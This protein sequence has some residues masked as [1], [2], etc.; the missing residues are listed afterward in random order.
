MS[1]KLTTNNL[2]MAESQ[3][4]QLVLGAGQVNDSI[5]QYLA[6]TLKD[7]GYKFASPS[8]LSFLS[9]LE[10]GVNYASDIARNLGVSRQ[11]VAKTVKEL[12]SAGYLDQVD[13]IGKQKKIIF[14]TNGE[15]LISDA[16]QLLAD[17][18]KALENKLA[19]DTVSSTLTSLNMIQKLVN[20]L[21][22]I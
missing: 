19:V 3:T 10:C 14:T 5:F 4:L 17:I 11:M 15:V 9:T 22:N 13:D 12:C 16:R 18:D 8:A 20:Q 21:N 2:P 1:T 6:N 7:K